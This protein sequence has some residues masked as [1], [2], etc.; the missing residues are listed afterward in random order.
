M[1]ELQPPPTN[2]LLRF[3]LPL[4]KVITRFSIKLTAQQLLK[5][6]CVKLER[7]RVSRQEKIKK[8][9]TI[10][11]PPSFVRQELMYFVPYLTL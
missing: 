3:T 9:N 4:G 11:T 7:L 10:G 5:T 8:Q 6:F 1:V 2:R